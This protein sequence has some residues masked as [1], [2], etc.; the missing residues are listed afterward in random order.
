LI[1]AGLAGLIIGVLVTAV[2]N[3]IVPGTNIGWLLIA[4]C[5]SS[6]LSS[7]SGSLIGSRQS[8]KKQNP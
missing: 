6:L 4:I 7:V 5:I 2:V 8:Q 1:L 3:L